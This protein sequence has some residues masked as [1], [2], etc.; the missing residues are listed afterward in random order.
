MVTKGGL[1]FSAATAD[2]EFRA[3]NKRTGK[4]L[5]ETD[6][7]ATGFTT[8]SIYEIDGKPYVVIACGGG[9]VKTK[10]GDAYIA[11]SLPGN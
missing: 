8:P 3:Y 11:F 4:I 7:P 6:L 1:L 9:K 10:A 2:G 5:C